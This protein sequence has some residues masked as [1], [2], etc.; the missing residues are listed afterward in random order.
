MIRKLTREFGNPCGDDFVRESVSILVSHLEDL[1]DREVEYCEEHNVNIH[2]TPTGKR[3]DR[4][5]DAIAILQ[6]VT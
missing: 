4:V 6:E 2:K 3:I 1:V 5:E